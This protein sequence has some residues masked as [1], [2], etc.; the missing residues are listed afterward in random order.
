MK[1]VSLRF[2]KTDSN[3]FFIAYRTQKHRDVTEEWP[4]INYTYSTNFFLASRK[5]RSVPI[6]DSVVFSSGNKERI[7]TG[8]ATRYYQITHRMRQENIFKKLTKD[9]YF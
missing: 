6:D 3:E 2:L 1:K 4:T 9:F 8:K 5:F 7:R